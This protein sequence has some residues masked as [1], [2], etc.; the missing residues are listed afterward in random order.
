MTDIRT[1][2]KQF[3]LTEFLPGESQEELK[4]DIPLRKSGIL[5]SMEIIRLIGFIESE[6]NI[7]VGALEADETNF[8]TLDSIVTFIEKKLSLA[9]PENR[10]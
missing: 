2:I 6:F 1:K 4:D 10:W 9:E 7:E 5:N 3:I 8:G